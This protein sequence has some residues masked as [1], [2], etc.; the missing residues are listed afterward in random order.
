MD[1]TDIIS[2]WF[3]YERAAAYLGI[4]VGTLRNWVS[5][6]RIPFVRR[7]RVVRFHRGDL[8][9]WLRQGECVTTEGTDAQK[10]SEQTRTTTSRQ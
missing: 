1:D 6:G 8:D 2:P 10:P 4:E 3:S 7:G 9:R 5:A